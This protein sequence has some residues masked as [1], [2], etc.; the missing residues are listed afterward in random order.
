VIRVLRGECCAL[1]ETRPGEDDTRREGREGSEEKSEIHAD[2]ML[3]D[4]FALF[5][6]PCR[7]API[8]MTIF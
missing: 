1:G 3:R 5:S 6:L 7:N 4:K 2:L 8:S